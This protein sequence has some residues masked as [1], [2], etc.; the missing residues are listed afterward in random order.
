MK[1]LI[2][3]ETAMHYVLAGSKLPTL[4]FVH[5]ADINLTYWDAQLA[6][7]A[8]Q[9]NV[10][11][12]DLPGHGKSGR[13]KKQ[14]SVKTMGQYVATF[15]KSLNLE[16]VIL[17]G[18]SMGGDVNLVAATTYPAPVIGF[19]GIDNFKNAGQPLAPE[20]Q[21]QSKEIIHNL[22][23]DFANTNEQYARMVLLTPQ[24]PDAVATQVVQDYRSA[25]QPMTI[26]VIEEVF[27]DLYLTERELL[28]KLPCKLHLINVDY[29]PTQEE[30]LQQYATTGYTFHHM[31][32]T[33][34]FPMI[35]NPDELNKKLDEVIREI[36][37]ESNEKA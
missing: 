1:S 30:P 18:H 22:H 3:D 19:I 32:G 34:H 21:Q 26:D 6:Y 29:M 17:I 7:F 11:A 37:Q 4:L 36:R 35:E 27:N 8:D 10:V 2:H 14:W 16:Q 33:S 24:T 15:I 13:D 5:G 31:A 12:L 28:P 23:T 9:Y 20:Y 25:Y